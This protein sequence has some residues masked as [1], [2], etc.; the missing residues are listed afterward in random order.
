M[1]EKFG[2]VSREVAVQMAVGVRISSKATIG[3]ATTG[4]AGPTGGTPENPVGRVFI[5]LAADQLQEVKQYDFFG[6]RQQVKLLASEVAL[7]RVRRY[8]LGI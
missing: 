6:G 4:I 2:P 8:L 1:L 7:D 3:I 5:A